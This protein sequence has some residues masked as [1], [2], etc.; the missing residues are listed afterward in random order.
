MK[1]HQE[2][3]EKEEKQLIKIYGEQYREYVER[4]CWRFIPGLI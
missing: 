1:E 3:H 4:V 2:I